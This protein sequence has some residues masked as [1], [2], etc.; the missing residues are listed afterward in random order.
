MFVALYACTAGSKFVLPPRYDI[1]SC[2]AHATLNRITQLIASRTK[3]AGLPL[4]PFTAHDL[5][6]LAPRS[7]K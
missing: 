2:M 4:E 3:E 6:R 7:T 1:H 5:R